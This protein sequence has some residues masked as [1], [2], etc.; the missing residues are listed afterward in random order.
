MANRLPFEVLTSNQ[1]TEAITPNSSSNKMMW[2]N[3]LWKMLIFTYQLNSFGLLVSASFFFEVVKWFVLFLWMICFLWWKKMICFDSN[4]LNR[5]RWFQ[6][7]FLTFK[8]KV[9]LILPFFIC[10]KYMAMI[11]NFNGLCY[12][13]RKW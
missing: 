3:F 6:I 4:I 8:S 10:S 2:R 7:D 9:Q 12:K 5:N 13:N 1:Q 11:W